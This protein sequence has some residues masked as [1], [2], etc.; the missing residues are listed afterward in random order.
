MM[1]SSYCFNNV[2]L[3][4]GTKVRYDLAYFYRWYANEEV[5]NAV[6]VCEVV[7]DLGETMVMNTIIPQ[8]VTFGEK[9]YSL[10]RCMEQHDGSW[11]LLVIKDA[12]LIVDFVQGKVAPKRA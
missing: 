8:G 6:S 12:K 5:S 11:N 10:G 3:P 7:E 1:M 9:A 2:S 4:P